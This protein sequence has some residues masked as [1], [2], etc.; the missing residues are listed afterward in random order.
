MRR[1]KPLAL[2][3]GAAL[4]TLAACGGSGGNDPGTQNTRT[5]KGE[6]GG[7]KDPKAAAPAADVEGAKTGGTITVYLPG[8]PGP[9]DLEGIPVHVSTSP[10]LSRTLRR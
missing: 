10:D 2:V 9:A 3:A 1:S 7:D 5:F 6:E 8:D 4:L